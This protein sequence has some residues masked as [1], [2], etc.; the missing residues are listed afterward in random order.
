MGRDL[1]IDD[2]EKKYL[3]K[4]PS[5]NVGDTISIDV[6]ITEGKKTRVQTFEGIVIAKDDTINQVTLH[7]SVDFIAGSVT[8]YQSYS[9]EVTWAPQHFGDPESL[10]QISEGSLIVD[11]NTFYSATLSY[12]SDLSRAFYDIEFFGQGT[13][14][15]GGFNW[16]QT[17]WG[18]E[19][20]DVPI[21]T[22]IPRNKQ[23]C[24][25]LT[26]KFTHKVARE[27]FKVLGITMKVRR[28]STKAYR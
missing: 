2:I 16:G 3:K 19:G 7:T 1:I 4:R 28:I 21:R 23:K 14:T 27:K 10:K 26:C 22:F 25:Y 5:F 13:G 18:G 24:R 6:N 9:S 17:A 12:Y 20:T 8:S 11:G 15:W